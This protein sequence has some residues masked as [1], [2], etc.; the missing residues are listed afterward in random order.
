VIRSH[1][2]V[3]LNKVTAA[4]AKLERPK[5]NNA[6][7]L[8]APEALDLQP[9]VKRLGLSPGLAYGISGRWCYVPVC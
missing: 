4:F 6:R 7:K 8:P 1:R 5:V 9:L 3:A 2:L